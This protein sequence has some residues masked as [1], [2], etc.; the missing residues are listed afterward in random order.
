MMTTVRPFLWFDDNAEEAVDLY[1]SLIPDSKIIEVN[2]MPDG[3]VLTLR[4]ELAGREFM[5]LQGGPHYKL[6]E[7]FS[8]FVECEDQAE[9]DRLWAKLLEGG[10]QEQQCGWLTD[11][12]GLTWQ[13]IPKALTELM[14]DPNP[15]KSGAVVNA[16][17]Q[18][19]KIDVAELQRA[20]DA[21]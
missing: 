14:G 20:Y 12:F 16:M 19:V 8:V 15:A 11:R 3:G 13:V 4:F 18:M 5:A 6:N 7:A 2:R 21:A 1:V 9:V 17:L 10:G